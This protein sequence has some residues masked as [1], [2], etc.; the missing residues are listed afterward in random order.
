MK[1]TRSLFWSSLLDSRPIFVLAL[2]LAESPRARLQLPQSCAF[3]ATC[4]DAPKG[5]SAYSHPSIIFLLKKKKNPPAVKW[6][7][8][9]QRAES[10]GNQSS[11]QFGWPGLD[12]LSWGWGCISHTLLASRGERKF[13]NQE[14]LTENIVS[15]TAGGQTLG[16]ALKN[17]AGS[18]QLSWGYKRRKESLSP[19]L[20]P[21]RFRGAWILKN[22]VCLSHFRSVH[23]SRQYELQLRLSLWLKNS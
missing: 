17:F 20:S 7:L 15:V 10:L 6:Q 21:P 22:F 8:S 16:L 9:T 4:L 18:V 13:L 14:L 1:R 23:G 19:T 11:C 12:H 3:P 2:A 5:I